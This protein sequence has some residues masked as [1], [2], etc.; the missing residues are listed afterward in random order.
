VA[1]TTHPQPATCLKEELNSTFTHPLG[2]HDLYKVNFTVFVF[3]ENLKEKSLWEEI[4]GKVCVCFE[5]LYLAFG[6]K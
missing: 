5:W 6:L 3:R 2:L 4:K 1:L